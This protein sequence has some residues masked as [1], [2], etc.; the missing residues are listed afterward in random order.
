MKESVLCGEDVTE[1]WEE[2][3]VNRRLV[4]AEF[5]DEVKYEEPGRV[6][7]HVVVRLEGRDTLEME[8]DS[9]SLVM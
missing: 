4:W 6:C 5:G 3:V 9:T 1:V 7:G 2:R 8:V